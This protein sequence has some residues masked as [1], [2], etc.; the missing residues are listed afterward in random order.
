MVKLNLS[1]EIQSLWLRLV[2]LSLDLNSCF[3]SLEPAK[4]SYLTDQIKLEVADERK[5]WGIVKRSQ[6]ESM[7]I[8]V[9]V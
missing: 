3:F 1:M 8:D 7:K 5:P 4:R 9:V 6:L 2:L